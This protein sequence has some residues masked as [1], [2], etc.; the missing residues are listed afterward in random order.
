MSLTPF[1]FVKSTA[2]SHF[3]SCVKI[4]N[5]SLW[6]ITAFP[7][8]RL[9]SMLSM[10]ES[11]GLS[12]LSSFL[13][14]WAEN[15]MPVEQWAWRSDWLTGTWCEKATLHT[16]RNTIPHTRHQH[17]GTGLSQPQ[18]VVCELALTTWS[19][20]CHFQRLES[21]VTHTYVFL[22]TYHHWIVW[23]SD[24]LTQFVPAWEAF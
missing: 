4:G 21:R 3:L 14:P 11:M 9:A 22:D 10:V 23:S 7:W 18:Q 6:Q 19:T 15:R 5:R 13:T 16:S 12:N 1:C 17:C 20:Q 2:E 8:H 24:E